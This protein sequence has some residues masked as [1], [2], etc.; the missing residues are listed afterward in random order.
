MIERA[1]SR[2]GSAQ[3]RHKRWRAIPMR[4]VWTQADSSEISGAVA[5][6][7][8]CG[9]WS[10]E[11]GRPAMVQLDQTAISRLLLWNSGAHA[12]NEASDTSGAIGARDPARLVSGEPAVES[13]HFLGVSTHNGVRSIVS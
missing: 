12:N 9:I 4:D 10:S 3:T 6:D 5:T 8:E 2:S 7:M 11:A 13:I 1:E